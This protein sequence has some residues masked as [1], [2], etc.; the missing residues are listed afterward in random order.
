MPI[1]FHPLGEPNYE[2]LQLQLALHFQGL[3]PGQGLKS[4][5]YKMKQT[6]LEVS[7]KK[8][9]FSYLKHRKAS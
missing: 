4:V 6:I 2:M 3:V 1:K 8:K 9:L 5:F 7:K